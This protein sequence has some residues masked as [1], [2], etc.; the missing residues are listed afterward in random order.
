MFLRFT[1]PRQVVWPAGAPVGFF[2]PAYDLSRDE[3]QP[4]WLRHEVRRELDW[5]EDALPRPNRFGV[6]TR[7]SRRPYA[8]VCWFRDDALAA[9]WHA[10]GLAA[11]LEEGGVP[12][13]RHI[14]ERPGQIVYWDQ[15]QVVAMPFKQ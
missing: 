9:I 7:R 14:C 3:M 6:S 4:E 8:G 15:S 10:H 12:V 11:L 13:T 5:F 1:T 2:G